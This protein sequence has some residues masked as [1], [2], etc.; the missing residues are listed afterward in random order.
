MRERL[1]GPLVKWTILLKSQGSSKS[2]K[3]GRESSPRICKG[4]YRQTINRRAKLTRK[5]K[6]I[7]T[8]LQTE[9]K[10]KS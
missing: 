4:G 2:M 5:Q 7:W 6:K 1:Y 3:H 10:N 8:Y 9:M